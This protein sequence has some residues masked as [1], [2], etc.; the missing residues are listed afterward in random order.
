VHRLFHGDPD[1]KRREF[2]EHL[3]IVRRELLER[4]R[5]AQELRH[6]HRT[7]QLRKSHHV[8]PRNRAKHRARFFL[9]CF[10]ASEGDQ[11]IQQR[12]PV[13]HASIGRLR[14]EPQSSRFELNPLLL[15]DFPHALG[16]LRNRQPLQVE[17]QTPGQHGGRQLLRIRRS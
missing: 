15:E 2:V 3:R 14:N 4:M 13:P 7:Q 8:V 5:A 12:Q 10:P 6:V 1:E 17:L 9:A 16:N 11:L